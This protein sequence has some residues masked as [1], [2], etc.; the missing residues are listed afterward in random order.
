VGAG[1]PFCLSAR[2]KARYAFRPHAIALS[3]AAR[4]SLRKL[5]WVVLGV[6]LLVLIIVAAPFV[7]PLK[8][9]MPQISELASMRL[10]QP[11]ALADLRLSLWPAPGAVANG[12]RVGKANDIAIED[13]R[14]KP[15]PLTLFGDAP[16]IKEIRA[17]KV[18]LTES[19][20]AIITRLS[21]RSADKPVEQTKSSRG[22]RIERI[23]LE[24][25]RVEH[26]TLRLPAFDLE[27]HLGQ[28]NALRQASF[29]ARD[30]TFRLVM[31][32]RGPEEIALDL[33]AKNWA[34]PVKDLRLTFRM[35][36]GQGILR[37]SRLSFKSIHAALYGGQVTGDAALAWGARWD[38]RAALD[39][40]RVDVAKLQRALKREA[41]L[42]GRLSTQ[43]K[44]SAKAKTAHALADHLALDAPFRIDEGALGGMDLSKAAE[45]SGGKIPAGGET[46]FEE[47]TGKLKVRGRVRRV[48][49]FCAR[50]SALVADGYVQ[51]SGGERL[52]GTLDVAIANTAGLVKVP[53][54]LS[55]TTS[56]PVA[57]P[58]RVMSLGAII[59]TV[60]LPGVGTAL[61]AAAGSLFE[62]HAG[63]R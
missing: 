57:T 63:C 56:N 62:G 4:P 38:L 10:G 34:V 3:M 17:R 45:V 58:S 30:G 54:K 32:P 22:L 52:S 28:G 27:L 25:V 47:L 18:T 44:L 55:G 14:I 50:S 15:A 51:V 36:A 16:V 37:G 43:A 35:L 23:V 33:Q 19:G 12:A 29:I 46:R 40:K 11:V 53:V 49:D 39:I 24:D 59:G 5:R 48:N 41:K 9:F 60:L 13:I 31:T 20:L 1:A 42:S 21:K 26:S 8:G 6:L 2:A 7:V 61:G